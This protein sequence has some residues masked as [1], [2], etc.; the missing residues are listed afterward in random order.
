M[1]FCNFCYR[2]FHFL[3]LV[4][5]MKLNKG[6]KLLVVCILCTGMATAAVFLIAFLKN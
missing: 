6:M 5:K 3:Q 4:L 1:P 2:V